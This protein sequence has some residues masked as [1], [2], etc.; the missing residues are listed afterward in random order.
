MSRLLL[1]S[2][3]SRLFAWLMTVLHWGGLMLW[4]SETGDYLVIPMWS[5]LIVFAIWLVVVFPIYLWVS[6][7]SFFWSK[8]F[9][10][11]TGVIAGVV[12][13]SLLG[14]KNLLL[15]WHIF[16][17]VVLIGI[18]IPWFSVTVAKGKIAE[19]R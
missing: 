2:F 19:G 8:K 12:I 1:Y 11:P 13:I 6:T 14:L 15:N 18:L 16:T 17:D 3:L 4:H 9:A 5:G 10:I 7:D